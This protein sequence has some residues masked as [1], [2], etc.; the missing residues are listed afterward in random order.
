[1]ALEVNIDSRLR[2]RSRA[3][4]R[5]R[6]QSVSDFTGPVAFAAYVVMICASVASP[7]IMCYGVY[8]AYLFVGSWIHG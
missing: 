6:L 3:A 4:K 1:M 2:D 5:R 8:R 7:V